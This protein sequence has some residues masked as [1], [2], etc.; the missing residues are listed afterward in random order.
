MKNEILQVI[1]ENKTAIKIIIFMLALIVI[2][3]IQESTPE[4]R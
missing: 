1:Y 4:M 2:G 3:H